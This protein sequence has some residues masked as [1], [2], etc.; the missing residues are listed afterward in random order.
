[1]RLSWKRLGSGLRAAAIMAALAAG[2]AASADLKFDVTVQNSRSTGKGFPK[3]GHY[4]VAFRSGLARI[5]GPGGSVQLFDFAVSKSAILSPASKTYV[6]SSLSDAMN[7]SHLPAEDLELTDDSTAK[8]GREFGVAVRKMI[9]K[10][11]GVISAGDTNE[12]IK[13]AFVWVADGSAVSS[14][15]CSIAPLA[16]IG[17]PNSNA[18]SFV[19]TLDSKAGIP[20]WISITWANGAT[21]EMTVDSIETADLSETT[22]T[23]PAKFKLAQ[24][25]KK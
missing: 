6:L 19:S 14:T 9:M 18:S 5:D 4:V 2:C 25:S 7:P 15:I 20:V 22:F 21:F 17:V 13:G 3:S 16:L 12:G 23:I 24:A 11:S 8:V 1:M 10:Q